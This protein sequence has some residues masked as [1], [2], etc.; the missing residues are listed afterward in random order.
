LNKEDKDK[1][2][3]DLYSADDNNR[4]LFINI[5]EKEEKEKKE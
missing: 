3:K 1:D 5:E 2:S 4:Y